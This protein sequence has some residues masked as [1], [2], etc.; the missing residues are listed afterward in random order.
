MDEIKLRDQYNLKS[1]EAAE[2]YHFVYIAIDLRSKKT[3]VLPPDF[4]YVRSVRALWSDPVSGSRYGLLGFDYHYG[5]AI[6]LVAINTNGAIRLIN[7]DAIDKAVAAL[8]P[9]PARDTYVTEYTLDYP[10]PRFHGADVD[11]PFDSELLHSV[12]SGTVTGLITVRL[13]D[14]KVTHISSDAPGR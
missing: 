11:I 10:P 2:N 7:T 12:D 14:G 13:A 8:L 4:I 3:L 6:L 1:D 9:K 5:T